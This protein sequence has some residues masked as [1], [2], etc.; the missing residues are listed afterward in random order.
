MSKFYKAL[1]NHKIQAKYRDL[2][3]NKDGATVIEF[4]IL[5]IPFTALLF[6]IIEISIVFFVG[7]ALTHSMQNTAREIRTGQFQASCGTAEAFKAKVCDG[8]SGLASCD[9]LRIDVKTSATGKFVPDLL[10]SVPT[11]EDP[12]APGEPQIPSDTYDNTA[13]GDVVVVRAQ[14]YHSLTIPSSFTR[15]SN[16]PGN[17]RLIGAKTAFRNEPFPGGCGS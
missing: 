3:K 2:I 15:L 7:S 17:T 4:A 9:K 11:T 5:V 16:Q 14:Y 13:A 8:M 12:D 6:S 10:P 1:L